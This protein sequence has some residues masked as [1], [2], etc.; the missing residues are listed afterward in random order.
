M[1]LPLVIF[2][3]IVQSQEMTPYHL[4]NHSVSLNTLAEY[5]KATSRTFS[6]VFT[7][8]GFPTLLAKDYFQT[9]RHFA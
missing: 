1:K 4:S 6:V 8:H 7:T 2:L 9:I 3:F 5:P